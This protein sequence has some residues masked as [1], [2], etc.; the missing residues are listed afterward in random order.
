MLAGIILNKERFRQTTYSIFSDTFMVFL[1]LLILPIVLAEYLLDLTATQNVLLSAISWIIY[2][3]FVLEFILKLAVA[4]KRIAFLKANKAYTAI[5]LFIIISPLL[6]P[7]SELF[8]ATPLLRA[9][10]I[11][12]AIRLSRLTAVLAASERARLSWRRINYRTYAIV[13]SVIVFG[14]LISFFKPSLRISETDQALLS[15]FIQIAATIYAIITGFV[16]ANVWGKYVSLIRVV[17]TEVASLRNV[18]FLA[19]QLESP[20][21]IKALKTKILEYIQ[22]IVSV[23]WK[24]TQ[25]QPLILQSTADIYG[26]LKGYFP[27]TA[28][29]TEVYTNLVDELKRSSEGQVGI[30]SLL[31]AQTPKILWTL[32]AVL[33]SVLIFGFFFTNY[34][35]QLLATL[36]LTLVSTAVALVA[37]I[38]YDMNDPFKFGF[39]AVPPIAYL[40]LE[41]FLKE[42]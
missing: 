21:L 37:T 10:R 14:F 33:S 36:T 5:S 28:G 32:I 16:I 2:S 17:N 1:A 15:Q 30:K 6:E 24:A 25:K 19:L 4:E 41:K 9:L 35:S 39:W 13:T 31:A 7:I 12:S 27:K 40:E 22:A 38:I 11:F 18:Y 29:Q 23:Y 8:V 26:S 42:H 20:E 34:D 3:V